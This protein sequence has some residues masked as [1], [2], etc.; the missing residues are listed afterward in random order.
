[1]LATQKCFACHKQRQTIKI[2][3]LDLQV[4]FICYQCLRDIKVAEIKRSKTN[5]KQTTWVKYLEHL[6]R[7]FE[8]ED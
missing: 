8:L 7:T 4:S 3:H 5:P 1:L 2:K 6:E